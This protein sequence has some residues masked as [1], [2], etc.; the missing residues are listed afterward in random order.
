MIDDQQARQIAA[1][2]LSAHPARG[3]DG[4]LELSILDEHTIEVA[5][6]APWMVDRGDGTL[7]TTGAA[8]PIE[9]YNEQYRRQRPV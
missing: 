4:V 9:H 3:R 7:H 8:H 6:N 1:D 5:G 2:W